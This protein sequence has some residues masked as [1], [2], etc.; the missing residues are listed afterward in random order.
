MINWKCSKADMELIA[1]IASRAVAVAKEHGVD[2]DQ[3]TAVMDINACHSNGCPL[4]LVGLAE[5]EPFDF[6][7]DVFGIRR[8]INRD[9]GKLENCFLP[10]Y[11]ATK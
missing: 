5:A 3:M 8:H 1:K 11:A 6:T 9:T 4:D 10:R 2:Y 7:H